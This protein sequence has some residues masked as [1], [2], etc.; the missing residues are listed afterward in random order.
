[1]NEGLLEGILKKLG[2]EALAAK[3][4]DDLSFSE[5]Q[6]LLLH[7]I[8]KKTPTLSPAQVLRQYEQDSYVYPSRIPQP[9]QHE[10]DLLLFRCLPSGTDCIELAPVAPLGTCSRTAEFNQ[11]RVVSTIRKNEVSADPTNLMALEAALRRRRSGGEVR[12]AASQRVLRSERVRRKGTFS[13]FKLFA[14]CQAGRDTGS[15]RFEISALRELLGFFDRFVAKLKQTRSGA[16]PAVVK[17]VFRSAEVARFF[18]IALEDLDEE[19]D[20]VALEFRIDESENWAYYRNL[21]V[22]LFISDGQEDW[23]IADG[24]DV[25]WTQRLL[26][27]KKERYFI[28]G[29]GTERVLD[30]FGTVRRK[31][32]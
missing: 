30:V 12:L 13:H 1:V 9:A 6:S 4:V 7:V 31:G 25:P 11:S 5:L 3:L 18:D 2:N 15:Y 23:F 8:E 20:H 29:M 14:F 24:G 27:N 10:L 21:R 19:L 22:R 32:E 16:G 17:V 28:S 26:S